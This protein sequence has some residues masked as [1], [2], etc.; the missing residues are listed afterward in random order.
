MNRYWQTFID[1]FCQCLDCCD[2]QDTLW[3][4]RRISLEYKTHH[5]HIHYSSR[6]PSKKNHNHTPQPSHSIPP[7]RLYEPAS[8]S[9]HTY[10][11]LP[12]SSDRCQTLDTS[13]SA[14]WVC[15][16]FSSK[17]QELYIRLH[18]LFTNYALVPQNSVPHV[19]R[20]GRIRASNNM[21]NG[22]RACITWKK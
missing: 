13:A 9:S 19:C 21:G 10:K 12:S 3:N 11:S 1:L 14:R 2:D 20:R 4:L 16:S 18:L 17:N 8:P 5:N 22:G 15:P 6:F 7:P